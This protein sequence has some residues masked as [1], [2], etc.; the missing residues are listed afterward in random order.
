[1]PQYYRFNQH[2]K[3]ALNI[4]EHLS[5][6]NLAYWKDLKSTAQ[7]LL[8]DA[9]FKHI[10]KKVESEHLVTGADGNFV[11]MECS[12]WLDLSRETELAHSNTP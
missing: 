4:D 8:S 11:S 1:M 7:D 12:T 6:S 9:Y 5:E 3:L 2:Y 10:F